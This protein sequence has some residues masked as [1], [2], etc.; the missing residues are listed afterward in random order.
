MSLN[1]MVNVGVL[2][3]GVMGTSHIETLT[4]SIAGARVVSVYD[5]DVARA[6]D[7]ASRVGAEV[8]DSADQLIASTDVDAVAIVAPDPL[9]EELALACLDAAKPTLCEKPLATTLDGS[10]RI[11]EAERAGGRRLIQVG[12]MRRFDPAFVQ[13]RRI[14]ESGDVGAIRVAHCVHRNAQ[15]HPSATSDGVIVNSMIHELDSVPWLL[16]DPLAAISVTP[17]RRTDGELLDPQVAVLET[18]GGIVVTAEVFVNAR[19]GYDVQCEVVGDLGTARLTSPYGLSLRQNGRDAI[20]VSSDFVTRFAD[21]YRIELD[22]WI[23]SVRDSEPAQPSAWDGH[24]A[25]LAAFAGVE[26]L[27]TR[28]RVEIDRPPTPEFYR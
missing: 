17:A 16:G 10:R 5:A 28:E 25:N 23:R 26:S 19:Y 3:A 13:L 15:A 18:A 2:G 6:K 27:H 24:L 4:R 8:A 20:S 11:V 9:H 1:D 12:F 22:H 21:A 7:V 14:V